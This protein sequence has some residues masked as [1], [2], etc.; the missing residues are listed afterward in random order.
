MNKTKQLSL[1][2]AITV[3]L[4]GCA[5]TDEGKTRA[6]GAGAGALIGGAIGLLL[7]DS[8]EAALLGA[9]VGTVAGDIYARNVVRK[10][11]QY[12]DSESYMNAVIEDAETALAKTQKEH[13][14]LLASYEQYQDDIDKF[15]EQQKQGAKVNNRLSKQAEQASKDLET[16]NSLIAALDQEI[17]L[18]VETLE[19]ERNAIPVALVSHSEST[20]SALESEKRQLELLKSQLASLDRRKLL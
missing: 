15:S 6:E 12:A 8:K 9:V 10:K 11:E 2:L 14:K 18:Q 19:Q 3:G 17:S 20:I 16:T 5:S 13:K 1:C 4:T 7:G